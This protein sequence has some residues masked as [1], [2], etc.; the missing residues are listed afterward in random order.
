MKGVAGFYAPLLQI[1]NWQE[2]QAME[3]KEFSR[4][5]SQIADILEIQD[6]NIFRIRSYRKAAQVLESVT[7]NIHKM[8]LENPDAI[9]KLPGIGAAMFSKILE[10]CQT[11]T[12]AEHQK[13][14]MAIPSSV[15]DML[16]LPGVGPK[17]IALFYQQGVSSLG[18][19]AEAARNQK[20]RPLPGIGEKTELKILRAIQER[21]QAA[22][23]FRISEA[24]DAAQLL[25]DHMKSGCRC[26]Q[27]S[28]AG[29]VRRWKETVADIDILVAADD[30]TSVMQR[31]VQ[32]PEAQQVLAQ[33]DT[34]S[35]ILLRSGM[36]ADLRVL[37]A[38]SFG[39]ALQYFTGSKEHNVVLRERAKRMGYKLNEYGAFRIADDTAVAGAEEEEI[40][41]LLDLQFV[42]P[43]LRENRGEIEAAESGALPRRTALATS[44]SPS[45]TTLSRWPSPTVWMKHGCCDNW[46]T[47]RSGP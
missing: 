38:S 28:T 8:A 3:N 36:Q 11:W 37:S 45:R 27:I 23:R 30:A 41:R 31:F 25:I 34:K 19:L 43:E 22:G 44:T 35:S 46:S 16:E 14:L 10:I 18:E 39:S 2:A 24:R 13:L 7:F 33:G 12:C 47:S 32:F 26:E 15:L 20:L 21:Q 6:A 29:S 17:K 4:I 40:Y 1:M 42:V 5:F 9:R